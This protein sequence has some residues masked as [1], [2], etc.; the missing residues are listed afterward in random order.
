MRGVRATGFRTS[1]RSILPLLAVSMVACGADARPVTGV[2]SVGVSDNAATTAPADDS[3]ES[4]IPRGADLG[5]YLLTVEDVP[6]G[7]QREQPI[8][9]ETPPSPP[10]RSPTPH[11]VC[12]NNADQVLEQV[13][14]KYS[15][16]GTGDDDP[17]DD[18]VEFELNGVTHTV[19]RYPPAVASEMVDDLERGIEE[20]P[21]PPLFEDADMSLEELDVDVGEESYGSALLVTSEKGT[22]SMTT[23]MWR[24]GDI[25]SVIALASPEHDPQLIVDL[26]AAADARLG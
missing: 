8:A 5:D 19:G 26:V 21:L 18:V 23:V 15:P 7:W 22:F 17:N 12:D 13:V 14:V 10:P 3:T 25:V 1:G 2:P 9:V 4:P 6:E 24:R 16:P 20:C 11:D